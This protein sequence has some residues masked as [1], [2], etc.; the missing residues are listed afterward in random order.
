MIYLIINAK[1]IL[2][3]DRMEKFLISQC[4]ISRLLAKKIFLAVQ[5]VY[6]TSSAVRWHGKREKTERFF[7]AGSSLNFPPL[8]RNAW[9]SWRATACVTA[10]VLRFSFPPRHCSISKRG[11]KP[12]RQRDLWEALGT[13]EWKKFCRATCRNASI[14]ETMA[15]ELKTSA[16]S[17][18]KVSAYLGF[19][20]F[21]SCDFRTRQRPLNY[22]RRLLKSFLCHVL[23]PYNCHFK[24]FLH[25]ETC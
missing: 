21:E 17:P 7:E 18:T 3:R 10:C 22:T 14:S 25:L 2:E 13:L 16:T 9:S 24:Q 8:M 6:C 15:T 1:N 4:L 19:S 5:Q 12:R 23:Q 11:Y 20:F